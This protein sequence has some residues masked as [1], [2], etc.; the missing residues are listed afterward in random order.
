MRH[1]TCDM[2]HVTC[3]TWHVTHD[4]WHMTGSTFS[5]NFSSLALTVWELKWHVTPDTWHVTHDTWHVSHDTQGLV[6][7]M[8]K[9]E[10]PSSNGSGFKR[11][12]RFGGKGWLSYWFNYEG[13]CRQP[14]LHRS[15]KSF[16]SY[17]RGKHI[18]VE[19]EACLKQIS[20]VTL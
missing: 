12:W 20:S 13:V 17:K 7:I 4:M 3:D 1:V 8:S 15:V 2:W 10:V 14:R 6:A 9:H 16:L 11:L 19:T 18:P 5:Q